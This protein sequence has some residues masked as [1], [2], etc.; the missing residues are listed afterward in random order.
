ML[1][2]PAAGPSHACQRDVR[3]KPVATGRQKLKLPAT[4][5]STDVKTLITSK[6]VAPSGPETEPLNIIVT[7]GLGGRSLQMKGSRSWYGCEL[8]A[9]I[10]TFLP[11]GQ[12]VC[13]LVVASEPFPDT[14]KLGDT[15]AFVAVLAVRQKLHLF[16]PSSLRKIAEKTGWHKT[17]VDGTSGADAQYG[18]ARSAEPDIQA[19]AKA[20]RTWHACRAN[21]AF[22]ELY[23]MLYY[24]EHVACFERRG[25]QAEVIIIPNPGDDLRQACFQALGFGHRADLWSKSM[26]LSSPGWRQRWTVPNDS[27]VRLEPGYKSN[28]SEPMWVINVFLQ[29]DPPEIKDYKA[30]TPEEQQGWDEFMAKTSKPFIFLVG[31]SKLFI[32]GRENK[33]FPAIYGCVAE[34]G[35][36]V[37]VLGQWHTT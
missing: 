21:W 12:Y 30:P 14:S 23:D 29:S 15:N 11:A 25:P 28:K 26:L 3:K 22:V 7:L 34:N 4:R 24:H 10:G 6:V 2:R 32:R 18:D 19:L 9:K 13:N 31:S 8:K 16:E 36:I 27:V 1:K 35:D 5:A 20:L 17:F 37:G 33:H